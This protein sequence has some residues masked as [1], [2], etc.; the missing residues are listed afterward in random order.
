M[1]RSLGEIK[2]ETFECR[3]RLRSACWLRRIKQEVVARLGDQYIGQNVDRL[4]VQFG[5]PTSIFS[6]SSGQSS[7][8][9]QLSAVIDIA[10][11]RGRGTASTRYCKVSVIA[12]PTGIV[13]QL[14]TEDSNAG[15]GVGEVVACWQHLRPAPGDEASK[16][17]VHQPAIPKAVAPSSTI[18]FGEL[19]F[20]RALAPASARSHSP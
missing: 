1:S 15:Y 16:L 17:A 4:V 20:G 12:S 7:Y 8:V 2:N 18:S 9:W 3:G 14:N 10:T 6:M 11:D 13:E 5:P 19:R